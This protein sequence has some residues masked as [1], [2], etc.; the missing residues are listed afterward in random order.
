MEKSKG[1]L[2]ALKDQD[3]KLVE[4]FN[5]LKDLV[6]TELAKISLGMKSKLFMYRG[7]QVVKEVLIK[8]GCYFER[9]IPNK[10]EEFVFEEV[11][12]PV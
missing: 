9:W 1:K 2:S 10:L 4:E 6:A 8:N 11:C 7:E 12:K 3:G 5:K